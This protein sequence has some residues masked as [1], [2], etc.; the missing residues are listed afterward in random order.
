MATIRTWP[1]ALA[2]LLV[3]PAAA[4][5]SYK[6]TATIRFV[7]TYSSNEYDAG[8]VVGHTQSS[9]KFTLRDPRLVVTAKAGAIAMISS[10]YTRARLSTVQSGF[11]IACDT[12]QQAF[13]DRVA[14]RPGRGWVTLKRRGSRASLGFGWGG[15]SID[16]RYVSAVEGD[17]T[18]P[19]ETERAGGNADEAGASAMAQRFGVALRVPLSSLMGGRSV[20]RKLTVHKVQSDMLD[21]TGVRSRLD[22]TYR[23]VLA[24]IG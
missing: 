4:E 12:A 9:T 11:R 13:T 21:G 3:L 24:R 2:L 19:A 16:R 18:E 7:G 17:C 20:S 14:K 8:V 6:Y 5:A 10:G 1:V 22:G 15:E 23:I